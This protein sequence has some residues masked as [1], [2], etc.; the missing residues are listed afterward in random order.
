MG[1]DFR[2]SNFIIDKGYI[3]FQ[4]HVKNNQVCV[5]GFFI[6]VIIMFCFA[7]NMS[8]AKVLNS[9]DIKNDQVSASEL[10]PEVIN[11]FG[12]GRRSDPQY[13][14]KRGMIPTGLTPE[15]NERVNCRGIDEYWA[16]DYSRK[17]GREAYHGGIDI[18]APQ[19]TPILAVADG[20][21]IAKFMNEDN[22]KGIEIMLRHSPQDTGHQI[23]IYTQY[24]HL[25][26]MPTLDIGQR[27]QMG[28][29]IGKTS[30]SGIS[31]REARKRHGSGGGSGRRG[32]S[33]IR[34]HALH[35]GVL[36]S[37]SRKYMKNKKLLVPVDAYWM[38]PNALYR[39]SPPFD[40]ASLK[41]LPENQKLIPIPYMLTSGNI[42]PADTKLIWPY[43]CS[44]K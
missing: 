24:T 4:L 16:M 1:A 44:L 39:K 8:Y 12:S 33:K 32:G 3:I 7:A 22:P 18:P 28:Q 37:T 43:S 29:V 6:I 27:V 31:G 23:W 13:A 41:A 26:K 35:F 30:N 5:C 10:Q 11:S 34:R 38:D 2:L 14:K 20:V 36:Y 21:V 15:F 19:G 17:R 25:L 42:I 9:Q 40:S